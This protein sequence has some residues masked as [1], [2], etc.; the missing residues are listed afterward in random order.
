MRLE[1]Q[2]GRGYCCTSQSPRPKTKSLWVGDS[3]CLS[4]RRM[5]RPSCACQISVTVTNTRHNQRRNRKD[6]FGSRVWRLP[7]TMDWPGG[8]GPGEAQCLVV[9]AQGGGSPLTSWLG[10]R[11][12]KSQDWGP[13]VAERPPTGLYLL[14][15][16]TPPCS[17]TGWGQS[18]STGAFGDT[19]PNH[20]TSFAF[21]FYP[22]PQLIGRCLPTFAQS[23]QQ[24]LIFSGNIL[25]DVP[26]NDV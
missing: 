20:S 5:N 10:V 14:K 11:G 21:L 1:N 13:Q 19:Y 2:S 16:P 23:I 17:A 15:V 25:T 7:S 8:F 9:G 4:S 18:L 26:R 12:R 6:L 22:G 3:G 24:M